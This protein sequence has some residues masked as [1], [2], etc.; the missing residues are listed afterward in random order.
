MEIDK[1]ILEKDIKYHEAQ[2][3]KMLGAIEYAKGLLKYLE[4]EEKDETPSK[5]K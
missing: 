4:K 2:I 1:D 3:A 5:T